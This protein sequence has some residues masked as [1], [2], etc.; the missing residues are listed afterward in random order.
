M[1]KTAEYIVLSIIT[2]IGLS[3]IVIQEKLTLSTAT[4]N[5]LSAVSSTL[6]VGGI[7]GVLYKKFIDTNHFDEIKDMLGLHKAVVKSGLLEFHQEHKTFSFE[8]LVHDSSELTVILNDGLGWVRNNTDELRKRFNR[9]SMTR[10]FIVDPEGVFVPA[11]AKKV[12]YTEDDYKAKLLSSK[13][14][15]ENLHNESDKKGTLEICYLKNFPTKSIFLTEKYLVLTPYQA[16]SKRVNVPVLVY[17][18]TRKELGMMAECHQDFELM[19]QESTRV[20]PENA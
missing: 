1:T 14:Q 8:S 5:A 11:I 6:L 18:S 2:I 16:S 19:Q 20:Y 4:D 3:L 7:L 15:L 9:P 17:D 10:L 12:N 13:S